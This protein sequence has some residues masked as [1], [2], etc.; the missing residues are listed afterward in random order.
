MNEACGWYRANSAFQ[1]C[2]TDYEK[3]LLI[4]V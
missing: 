3:L 1:T 4:N 2:H